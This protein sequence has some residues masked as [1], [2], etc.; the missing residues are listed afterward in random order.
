MIQAF[1][2]IPCNG[3][4]YQRWPGWSPQVN[5][6]EQNKNKNVSWASHLI[7]WLCCA[8]CSVVAVICVLLNVC[9]RTMQQLLLVLAVSKK[10][11]RFTSQLGMFSSAS[12]SNLG[13]T[14]RPNESGSLFLAD[15]ASVVSKTGFIDEE[16]KAAAC[17]LSWV[18]SNWSNDAKKKVTND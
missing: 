5:K 15:G 8:C 1:V 4:Y 12:Q 3:Q 14:T 11:L 13:R 9:I 10:S 17:D 16:E 7:L 2:N 18:A 6:C